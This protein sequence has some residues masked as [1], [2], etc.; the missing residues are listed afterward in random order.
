M[1]CLR[2]LNKIGKVIPREVAESKVGW[3]LRLRFASR[4]M[5]AKKQV[6]ATLP[7]IL[8]CFLCCA[9]PGF[10]KG[11]SKSGVD[12]EGVAVGGNLSAQDVSNPK[13]LLGDVL[14]P[15]PGG[16]SLALR[17]VC[18]PTGGYLDAS[19]E[20]HGVANTDY[21]YREQTHMVKLNAPFELKDLPL[22]WGD[23]VRRA[24]ADDP[25]CAAH[26]RHQK[27]FLYFI[28]KYELSRAQWRA[29]MNN[30]GDK[31]MALAADDDKPQTGMSWFDVLEFSRR[32]TDW[33]LDNHK[34]FLP[35]FAEAKRPAYVRL[36]SEEEWEYA[37]RGGHKVSQAE[38][39]AVTVHPPIPDGDELGQYIVARKYLPTRLSLAPIGSLKPSVL[40][41]HDMAGNAAEMVLSPFQL[42]FAGQRLGGD[43]GFVLKGGSYLATEEKEL[44]PGARL[45]YDYFWGGKAGGDD[46]VGFRLALGG[47][48]TPADRFGALRDE[49]EQ[50]S[51]PVAAG[52]GEVDDAR[53]K[54]RAAA[55]GI[56]DSKAL[57]ALKEAEDT[58][59]SYHQKVNYSE[60]QMVRETLLGAMFALEL[61][62]QSVYRCEEAIA[63]LQE[64][65]KDIDRELKNKKKLEELLQEPGKAAAE[66]AYYK[67]KLTV[68]NENL[69]GCQDILPDQKKLIRQ[70][71]TYIQGALFHYLGIRRELAHFDS[72]RIEA[73][74]EE[75]ERRFAQAREEKGNFSGSIKQRIDI[76]RSHLNYKGAAPLTEIDVLRS[77]V[78]E[79]RF[80][81]IEPYLKSD[82]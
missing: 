73:Q 79:E 52:G 2:L 50:R 9:G 81:A 80:K 22:A 31:P 38:R 4:R 51:K 6:A 69:A 29:V 53:G 13:P 37:A 12:K 60:E 78:L 65:Q 11:F 70:S 8:A 43:G 16:L 71:V 40:G 41:L 27:P 39:A 10:A 57:N 33:L 66:R 18:V 77:V 3:I 21:G 36:P 42:V 25:G 23:G 82:F 20:R 64:N 68:V 14:L 44:H 59:A 32:Y 72:G 7:L 28:G 35:Y 58:V 55:S 1:I 54:I 49:W 15:M 47:I 34:E 48:F 62:W 63:R 46:T 26:S 5:T 30:A 74:M 76:L 19:E 67:D 17:P 56:T 24:I 61:I 75:V 45:E